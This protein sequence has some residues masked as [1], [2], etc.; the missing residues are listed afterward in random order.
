MKIKSI[1]STDV[2]FTHVNNSLND[3]ARLMWDKDCGALP[4]ID[5]DAVVGMIT[6]RDIAMAA[7]LQGALLSHLQVKNAMSSHLYFVNEEAS[8]EAALNIMRDN[9]IR[10]LPVLDNHQKLVGI[11]A[12]NDIVLEYQTSHGKAIRAEQ[13]I[14]AMAGICSHQAVEKT[15]VAA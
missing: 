13:V 2:K 3:A 11:V 6:D 12:L 8:L 4:V 9:R 15:E 10:R 14:G 7:Y 1:M 5:N